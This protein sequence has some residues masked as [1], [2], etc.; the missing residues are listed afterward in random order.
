M[1]S[2]WLKRPLLTDIGREILATMQSHS[3]LYITS[4]VGLLAL[5]MQTPRRHFWTKSKPFGQ[6]L[7]QRVDRQQLQGKAGI[8]QMSVRVHYTNNGLRRNLNLDTQWMEKILCGPLPGT[9]S[10]KSHGR[11]M[12]WTRNRHYKLGQLMS[13]KC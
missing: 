3:I 10:E 9:R 7:E 8:F 2:T 1:Q 12:W 11:A 5:L 13:T 6:N 4:S